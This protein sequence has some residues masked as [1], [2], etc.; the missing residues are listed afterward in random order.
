MSLEAIDDYIDF[1]EN[2]APEYAIQYLTNL[3]NYHGRFYDNETYFEHKKRGIDRDPSHLR[4]S[5]VASYT[6]EDDDW[7]SEITNTKMVGAWNLLEDILYVKGGTN[8]YIVPPHRKNMTF[9]N[10][11]AGQWYFNM[12]SRGG[13][14]PDFYEAMDVLIEEASDYGMEE[15]MK[16]AAIII[17]ET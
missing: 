7:E 2:K 13:I 10:K 12:P 17:K 1:L 16:E 8:E 3:V 9:W 15:A 11:Y 14:S 4:D 6:I 5:W